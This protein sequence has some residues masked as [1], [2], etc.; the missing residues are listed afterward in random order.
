MSPMAW[1]AQS[2]A[3]MLSLLRGGTPARRSRDRQSKFKAASAPDRQATFRAAADRFVEENGVDTVLAAHGAVLKRVAATNGGEWAG[4]CPL[5]GGR[6][7]L[8]AWPS[9]PT[10][11]GRAWC[12]QCQFEGDSLRWSV[13]L[14]GGDPARHGATASVLRAVGLL[15]A[16]PFESRS[17]P[18]GL[19]RPRIAEQRP[20]QDDYDRQERAAI[21][22]FDAGL[23]RLDAERLAG[24]TGACDPGLP[25]RSAELLS[26]LPGGALR[27]Q[28]RGRAG[29]VPQQAQQVSKLETRDLPARVLDDERDQNAELLHLL[30]GA[31]SESHLG[32]SGSTSPQQP[33]QFSKRPLE[34]DASEPGP[35]RHSQPDHA[36]LEPCA[37]G[38]SVQQAQQVSKP[39]GGDP[40]VPGVAPAPRVAGHDDC[41]PYV[42][43]RAD[44]IPRDRCRNCRSTRWW[45]AKGRT[46]WICAACHPPVPREELIER[47]EVR[48]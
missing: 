16:R 15:E 21:Y 44:R 4:P 14:R 36:S 7:R 45:R 20:I 13:A 33:Q 35:E 17:S 18:D 43:G 6:D 41:H 26:L 39:D 23:P 32:C 9:P 28:Q 46:T 1:E 8:R 37:R 40:S 38:V 19:Q 24:I 29:E 10:G 11:R 5:C 31:D 22:E 48:P 30:S 42:D 34:A 2:L 12:R 27:D 25:A 3:E 47:V